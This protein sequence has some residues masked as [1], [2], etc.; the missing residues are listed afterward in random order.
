[1]Y[2]KC[3]TEDRHKLQI[4]LFLFLKR[5]DYTLVFQTKGSYAKLIKAILTVAHLEELVLL[6]KSKLPLHL[7]THFAIS[8]F[9]FQLLQM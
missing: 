8:A 1:M 6:D 9:R 4:T 2:Y 5:K 7:S 3:E